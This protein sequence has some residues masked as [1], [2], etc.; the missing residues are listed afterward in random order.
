VADN[1]GDGECRKAEDTAGAYELAAMNVSNGVDHIRGLLRRKVAPMNAWNI[2]SSGVLVAMA[3]V[4]PHLAAHFLAG[5]I[6]AAQLRL[7]E[8][9]HDGVSV[10]PDLTPG[11]ELIRDLLD[12]GS[13]G[14]EAWTIAANRLFASVEGRPGGVVLGELADL[15]AAGELLLAQAD[16]TA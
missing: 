2:T 10:Y 12:K 5:V 15:L 9:G 7:V 3:D 14:L 6:A 1:T 8:A 13:S 16:H 11:V 4:P